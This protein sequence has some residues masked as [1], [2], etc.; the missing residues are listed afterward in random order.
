MNVEQIALEGSPGDAGLIRRLK[1]DMLES[2]T[3][4][5]GLNRRF[6]SKGLRDDM[7]MYT[8][9][10]LYKSRDFRCDAIALYTAATSRLVIHGVTV[11]ACLCIIL[12][13]VRLY[14]RCTVSKDLGQL[15]YVGDFGFGKTV[16][17]FTQQYSW[18]AHSAFAQAGVAP[19]LLLE[20]CR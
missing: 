20:H 10:G 14:D 2:A 19:K 18:E 12:T 13:S 8:H 7:P 9:R 15:I 5:N 16:A 6:T 1:E 4:S 17:K 3:I 11:R